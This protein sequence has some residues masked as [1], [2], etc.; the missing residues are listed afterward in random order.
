MGLATRII[1]TLLYRG[2]VLVKG[3]R[4]DSWR[5]VGHVLQA[6]R[7]HAARQ[8]DE[9]IILDIGAT[10]EGRGPNF[11]LVEKITD[12]NFTPIT[13]GGG[14]R[15]IDDVRGLLKAG[16]DKVAIGTEQFGATFF[17][18]CCEKFGSQAIVAAVDVKAGKVMK[19]CGT[20]IANPTYLFEC[21]YQGFVTAREWAVEAVQLGAGE[22]LLTS[23]DREGTMDGY[24]IDL[25][26]EV[27][28]AVDCPVI[29]HGGCSGYLDMLHAIQAGAS[30]V[31]AGAL[32]QFSDMTPKGAAMFLHEQAV[33][34]RL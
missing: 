7:I 11:A 21:K 5:S 19:R 25:I 32:F 30:A 26:R 8:V 20:E 15:T 24:D 22:I 34:V 4:F 13:V 2:D 14:V 9:L 28:A 17:G 12:G 31:A 6:A 27:S 10:P 18:T 33:E 29:A 23:I 3:A 16:A 1:P